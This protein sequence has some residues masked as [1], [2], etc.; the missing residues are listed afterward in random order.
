[1]EDEARNGERFCKGGMSF[2]RSGRDQEWRK[3]LEEEEMTV[4]GGRAQS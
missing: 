3:V 4:S 1:M 2:R